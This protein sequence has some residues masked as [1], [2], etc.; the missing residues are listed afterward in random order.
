MAR[1]TM[2]SQPAPEPR[3][4]PLPG[5]DGPSRMRCGRLELVLERHRGT[6]E[7]LVHDGTQGLRYRLGLPGPGALVLFPIP[8]SHPV[9]VLLRDPVVLLP[10][11]RVRG[12]LL[13]PLPWQVAWQPAEG[14]QVDVLELLPRQLESARHDDHLVH[15]VPSPFYPPGAAPGAEDGVLV[16]VVLTAG[17]GE[18]VHPGHVPL[19][20]TG[21]DLRLLR[22]RL[23]AR[24][25][26][27]L[28]SAGRI[29]EV[30]RPWLHTLPI[31]E[32]GLR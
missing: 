23:I 7:L 19:T 22:G 27:I 24:P 13:V 16:P 20:L 14:P 8:P 26:R 28:Y 15:R 29:R 6:H 30:V 4:L 32:G 17:D 18:R 1:R 11:G 21:D 12:Y 5:P 2:A 10:G 9:H 31:P 25:R 3:T